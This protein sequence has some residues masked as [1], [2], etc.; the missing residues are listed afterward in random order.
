M[1]H[2]TDGREVPI[3]VFVVGQL[4][5]IIDLCEHMMICMSNWIVNEAVDTE[6]CGDGQRTA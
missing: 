3:H 5:S 6:E 1:A 2:P 4:I